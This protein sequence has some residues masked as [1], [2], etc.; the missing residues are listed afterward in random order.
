MEGEHAIKFVVD[1]DNYVA[2]SDETNNTAI[3][4]VKAWE[5][6]P[7][8]AVLSPNRGEQWTFGTPRTITWTSTGLTK[9]T[10]AKIALQFTNGTLCNLSERNV[11]DGIQTVTLQENQSCPGISYLLSP[12]QYKAHVY[13]ASET[14]DKPLVSDSSDSYFSIISTNSGM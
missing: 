1:S 5:N 14:S 2:E 11:L 3:S 10:N 9:G 6:Q 13:V 7:S 4:Y 12:G 8:I